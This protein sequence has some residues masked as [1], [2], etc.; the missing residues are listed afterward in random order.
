MKIKTKLIKNFFLVGI[1]LIIFLSLS[2][3]YYLTSGIISK[4]NYTTI[5]VSDAK[6]LIESDDELFIL[7]VRN[8]DEFVDGHISGAYLIPVNEIEARKGELPKNK[9]RS[10]LVYCRSGGR[11]ATASNTLDSLGYTQVNNMDGGFIAWMD[12]EYLFETG[13]FIKPTTTSNTTELSSGE[14]TSSSS[15]TSSTTT[16]AFELTFVIQVIGL[17]LILKKQRK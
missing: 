6:D 1:F 17:L 4:V 2:N 3:G 10:I 9:S 13:P 15:S 7:D 14:Q 12:E 5:S 11:S 8:P 16:P